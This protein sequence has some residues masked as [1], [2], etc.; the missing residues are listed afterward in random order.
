M[1]ISLRRGGGTSKV[2]GLCRRA[3]LGL[4]KRFEV[5]IIQSESSVTGCHWR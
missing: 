1:L 5:A 3:C 4:R 2:L